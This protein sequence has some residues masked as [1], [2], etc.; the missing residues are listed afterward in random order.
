MKEFLRKVYHYLWDDPKQPVRVSDLWLNDAV[1]KCTESFVSDYLKDTNGVI[2]I[3]TKINDDGMYVNYSG[4]DQA[5][6]IGLCQL[7]SE[8]IKLQRVRRL[9]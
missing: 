3:W 9:D 7:A 5:R 1:K 2:I 8:E 4:I 6:A